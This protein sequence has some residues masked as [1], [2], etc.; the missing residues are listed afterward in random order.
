M[1]TAPTAA[2]KMDGIYRRQRFFYD[3]TRRYY[4]LGRDQ[5]IASLDVPPQGTVLEIGCGTAR[6]LVQAARRYPDM[7]GYGVDVSAE[8]LDT[9]RNSVW[10]AGVGE[11]IILA[12]GDA[13][14]FKPL[15]CFGIATFDRVFISYSLSMIPSWRDAVNNAMECVSPG[16][17]LHIADFGNFAGY[18]GWVRWLQ[19]TWLAH[20]SVTPIPGLPEKLEGM[21]KGRGLEATTTRLY[22]GYAILASLRRL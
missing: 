3:I 18:P 22:G 2:E 4:L 14:K 9:A 10:Q 7:R 20:F 11:R 16:G 5:L 6:N 21:A 15:D 12:E 13:T 19:H 8:M 17:V 1:T